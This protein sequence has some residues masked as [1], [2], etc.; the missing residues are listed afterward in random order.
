MIIIITIT[1]ILLFN[2]LQFEKEI[3]YPTIAE[4]VAEKV[5]QIQNLT[6]I[7]IITMITIILLFNKL[8]LEKEI[9]YPSFIL[10]KQQKKFVRFK[11]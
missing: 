7:T 11:I 6:I 2:E 10:K 3:Y 1:I 8:Q 4:K 9:Y 5:C